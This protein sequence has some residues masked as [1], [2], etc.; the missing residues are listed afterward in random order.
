MVTFQD[1]NKFYSRNSAGK[2]LM[3][4]SEIRTAFLGA[5]SIGD[6]V[7]YFCKSRIALL[8]NGEGPFAFA[9]PYLVV[10]IV[11]LTAIDGSGQINPREAKQLNIIPIDGQ[12]TVQRFNLDGYLSACTGNRPAAG[13]VQ[14]FREGSIEAARPFHVAPKTDDDDIEFKGCFFARSEIYVLKAIKD[15]LADL[16]R[17]SVSPPIVVQLSLVG[18]KGYC[19][20]DPNQYGGTWQTRSFDRDEILL[21]SAW[22]ENSEQSLM[23]HLRPIFEAFWQAAGYE[24]D[25]VFDSASRQAGLE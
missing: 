23:E 18:L 4:V 3:D 16:G 9:G 2:F 25:P 21:P 11:P 20:E 10:H 15:Y 13:Y 12:S 7:R 19:L 24:M 8:R 6:R 5:G 14:F 1:T 17:L 22:I